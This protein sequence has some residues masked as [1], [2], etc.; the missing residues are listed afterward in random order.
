MV[1]SPDVGPEV[2]GFSEV[3]TVAACVVVAPLRFQYSIGFHLLFDTTGQS[4]S[5]LKYKLLYGN[6]NLRLPQDM[7]FD[8]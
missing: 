4:F 3:E 7:M 1:G 6:Y 8:E 5:K 2:V